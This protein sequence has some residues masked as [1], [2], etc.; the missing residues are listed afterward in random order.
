MGTGEALTPVSHG[1]EV[2]D[3]F[4]FLTLANCLEAQNRSLL[5]RTPVQIS[6]L[7]LLL[8][9]DIVSTELFRTE[10]EVVTIGGKKVGG[11]LLKQRVGVEWNVSLVRM[12]VGN[13]YCRLGL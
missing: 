6:I 4:K 5:L 12:R 11:G 10:A 3:E 2:D 7:L 13:L 8:R 9:S 1:E